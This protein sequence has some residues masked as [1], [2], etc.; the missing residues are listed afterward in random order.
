VSWWSWQHASGAGWDASGAPIG[1]LLAPSV[2]GDWA[3]YG[4]GAKG[5]LVVWAQEHLAGAGQPVTING[6][7]DA[8]TQRAVQAFQTATG[9]PVTG[10]VD[11]ATW[12]VLDAVAPVPTDWTTAVT[13]RSSLART[14]SARR[15]APPTA[16][17][18]A[19]RDELK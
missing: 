11:T 17:L 7:F 14:A 5:D 4:L 6:R 10:A 13:A 19:K 9:L 8:V 15:S 18:P 2:P 1:A 3:T 16:D 12:P